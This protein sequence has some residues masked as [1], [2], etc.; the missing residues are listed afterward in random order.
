M[1][2][3]VAQACPGEQHQNPT[4]QNWILQHWSAQPS[5]SAKCIPNSLLMGNAVFPGFISTESDAQGLHIPPQPAR[6][7]VR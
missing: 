4:W 2:D 5:P 1:L 3:H 7:E 6:A